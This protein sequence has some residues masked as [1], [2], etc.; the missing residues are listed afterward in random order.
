LPGEIPDKSQGVTG[1][2]FFW[3]EEQ[4][5]SKPANTAIRISNRLTYKLPSANLARGHHEYQKLERPL[6][7]FENP[8]AFLSERVKSIVLGTFWGAIAAAIVRAFSFDRV[9]QDFLASLSNP[10][11]SHILDRAS[12]FSYG[13]VASIALLLFL[14]L[15]YHSLLN[16]GLRSWRLGV[17]TGL[18]T[19]AFTIC[20]VILMLQ[21]VPL[22]D[23]I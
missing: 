14:A 7:H 23:R 16:R 21:R 3:F 1:E 20:L 13:C 22:R 6:G 12:Y 19:Q 2:S 17:T 4:K 5:R 15:R 8:L 9:F 10:S 11:L 18:Q